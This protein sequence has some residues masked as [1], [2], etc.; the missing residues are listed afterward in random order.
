MYKG[1]LIIDTRSLGVDIKMFLPVGEA[2]MRGHCCKIWGGHFRPS[3]S[4]QLLAEGGEYLELST[5]EDH[6]D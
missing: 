3:A 1:H 5:P 6:G 4:G 2:R